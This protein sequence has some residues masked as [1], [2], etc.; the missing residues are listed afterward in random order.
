[1][2]GRDGGGWGVSGIGGIDFPD[3]GDGLGVDDSSLIQTGSGPGTHL[4]MRKKW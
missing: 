3:G 4:K 2:K 1:M